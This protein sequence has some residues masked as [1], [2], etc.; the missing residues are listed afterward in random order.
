MTKYCKCLHTETE[1]KNGRC[2]AITALVGSHFDDGTCQIS[3][4]RDCRC[5]EFDYSETITEA[6]NPKPKNERE[7]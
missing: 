5:L 3:T 1:H 2:E 6:W 4:V 7:D